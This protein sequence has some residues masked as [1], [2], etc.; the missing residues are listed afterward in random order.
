[1]YITAAEQ[2]A[3]AAAYRRKEGASFPQTAVGGVGRNHEFFRYGRNKRNLRQYRHRQYCLFAG[4]KSGFTGRGLSHCAYCARHPP[5][6]REAVLRSG[7]GRVCRRRQRDKS[8]R[9]AYG[10]GGALRA[11]NGRRFRRDDNGK[12]QSSAGQRAESFRQIRRKAV[13]RKA[14]DGVAPYEQHSCRQSLRKG[15]RA[16]VLRHRKH[17]LRR[18]FGGGGA[19]GTAHCSGLLLRCGMQ[20]RAHAV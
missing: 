6:G 20:G 17:L 16:G 3:S 9:A 13:P 5:F 14:T 11:Q 7:A 18:R 8:R 2:S 1:M 19:V 4:E 15:V 12:P 10:R